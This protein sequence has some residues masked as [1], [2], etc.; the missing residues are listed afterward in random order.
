MVGDSDALEAVL[1]GGLLLTVRI[2]TGSTLQ[3]AYSC[4]GRSTRLKE[5]TQLLRFFQRSILLPT[6]SAEGGAYIA[7]AALLNQIRCRLGFTFYG[8]EAAR[9]SQT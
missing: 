9:N 2:S 8:V 3:L 7:T 1:S 5:I 4:A 6:G